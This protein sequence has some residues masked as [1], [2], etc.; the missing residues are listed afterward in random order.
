LL[1]S[2][3][4]ISRGSLLNNLGVAVQTWFQ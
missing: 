4:H 2:L 1:L 3:G